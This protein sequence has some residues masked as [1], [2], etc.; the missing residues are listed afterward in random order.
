MRSRA[1]TRGS[2]RKRRATH[3][4]CRRNASTGSCCQHA[5][6]SG[7]ST[8]PW[9]MRIGSVA[10][11]RCRCQAGSGDAASARASEVAHGAALRARD[12]LGP[13]ALEQRRHAPPLVVRERERA[14]DRG[15]ARP[16]RAGSRD[17]PLDGGGERVGPVGEEQARPRRTR[18]SAPTVVETTGRPMA[19]A[20]RILSREPPP[21]RSGTT[22][23]AARA[24][25]SG[26]T[27]GTDPFTRHARDRGGPARRAT[28]GGARPTTRNVASG[29]RGA[30]AV[31]GSRRGTTRRASWL[32]RQSSEPVN[33]S[34]CG[35][36]AAAGSGREP[37]AVHARSAPRSRAPGPSTRGS[38]AAS[39]SLTAT[40]PSAAAS[41]RALE[42]RDLAVLERARRRAG[43]ASAR[44]ARTAP[45]CR[46][47][48][49]APR[50]RRARRAP[51]ARCTTSGVH[52]TWITSGRDAATRAA[53]ASRTAASRCP[54][55]MYGDAQGHVAQEIP[56][57]AERRASSGGRG[58]PSPRRCPSP[59]R[60]RARRRATGAPRGRRA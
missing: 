36:T 2:T 38:V 3:A 45:R 22:L 44:R 47:R 37:L 58:G 10:R 31:A 32:G 28:A 9:Y 40:T 50:R 23:S 34:S 51:R 57:E 54:I 19:S 49:C 59:A 1:S 55:T 5:G 53:T 24:R 52:S 18:P 43:R 60:P 13:R 20:S 41:A 6:A 35:S 33:R 7:R 4:S 56:G 17:R 14:P 12:G 27:S 21:T 16:P 15:A 11:L 30:H 8:T 46:S 48:R 29:T 39:A 25:R 42:P 26:R